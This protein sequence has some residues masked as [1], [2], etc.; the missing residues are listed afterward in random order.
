MLA[1]YHLVGCLRTCAR[2]VCHAASLR[3]RIG[4]ELVCIQMHDSMQRNVTQS[5]D[6]MH[7]EHHQRDVPK[8][9]IPCNDEE[10]FD[11][12]PGCRPD[13][14]HFTVKREEIVIDDDRYGPVSNAG[15]SRRS[16]NKT[17]AG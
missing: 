7:T 6:A 3:C 5:G 1:K 4:V 15:T 2:R 14:R 10:Y 16:S 9:R 12:T 11:E 17:M 8:R 13:E